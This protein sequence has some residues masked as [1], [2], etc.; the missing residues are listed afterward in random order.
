M[1]KRRNLFGFGRKTEAPAK[2]L[3]RSTM[4]LTQAA[5]GAKEAGYRGLDFR[6]WLEAKHLTD[7]SSQI[8]SRLGDAY[9]AGMDDREAIDRENEKRRDAKRAAKE[10]RT[11]AKSVKESGGIIGAVPSE[12]ALQKAYER[13]AKT[14]QEA[15]EMAGAKFNPAFHN[16]SHDLIREAETSRNSEE[17]ARLYKYAV[18][19]HMAGLKSAVEARAQDLRFSHADLTRT[20]NSAKFDRCVQAVKAKGSAVD[21]YAVCTAAGARNPSKRNPA[22]AAAEG[23]E[24]FHGHPPDEEVVVTKKV[25]FHQHLSGAGE[26]RKLVVRGIDFGSTGR[27][28]TLK[29]F[30]GALLAFNES[31]NQLFVEGGDQKIN[32]EDFGIDPSGAHELETLGQV[33]SIDYFTEKTHLGDEGGLATYEHGFRMTNENGQHIVVKIAKYPDLIY[34]VPDEQLLFSGGSYLIRAEGIDL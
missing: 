28:I 4:T 34:S 23:F 19:M 8:I 18:K 20:Y 5:R 15:L 30:G 21:P 7:R 10:A 31:K 33:T 32:P 22:E 6:D 12:A 26:L 14:L 3:K 1:A 9:R 2:R 25:H 13:G 11:D 29:R 16:P 17:L 27:V 24:Q